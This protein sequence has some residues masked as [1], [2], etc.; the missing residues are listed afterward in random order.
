MKQR[1][2]TCR[3]WDRTRREDGYA[4]CTKILKADTWI[5]G[6]I[7]YPDNFGCVLWKKRKKKK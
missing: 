4:P 3:F 7:V 6:R 5:T 2:K 1:C